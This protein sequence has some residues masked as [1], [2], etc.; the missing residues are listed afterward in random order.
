MRINKSED[1]T[2]Q[3]PSSSSINESSFSSTCYDYSEYS[4]YTSSF[5]S[6][7]SS[8]SS[9][10]ISPA[11]TSPAP[12]RSSDNVKCHVS[13][14]TSF[15]DAN[16]VTEQKYSLLRPKTASST[17][18]F[19]VGG[20]RNACMMPPSDK[21]VTRNYRCDGNVV[22]VEVRKASYS[23]AQPDNS[24]FCPSKDTLAALVSPILLTETEDM[25][26]AG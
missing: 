14:Q 26:K 2:S 19:N 24:K 22:T 5:C 6:E 21:R 15:T 23:R 16:D 7:S 12:S 13:A 8:D 18:N 10:P 11:P 1:E 4:S 25:P 20:R 17:V 3:S 9:T